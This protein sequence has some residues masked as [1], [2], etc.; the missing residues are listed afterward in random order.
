MACTA[1]ASCIDTVSCLRPVASHLAA[2]V[3]QA[4]CQR[5]LTSDTLPLPCVQVYVD[6]PSVAQTVSILRGLRERYE[7]HHGV[8]ISDS[9][10]VEAAVL[11]DRY[12]ADRFLPD[13]VRSKVDMAKG[14]PPALCFH[15]FSVIPGL[16][17]WRAGVQ[18]ACVYG[19]LLPWAHR[20][21]PLCWPIRELPDEP[22]HL[23]APMLYPPPLGHRLGG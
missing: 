3:S 17:G 1:A 9:A 5:V 16:L 14:M 15:C 11:S 20:A 6:Q 13:K 10:L 8:R 23:A 21:R 7:V 22:P 4:V 18:I 12:L 2:S 19:F